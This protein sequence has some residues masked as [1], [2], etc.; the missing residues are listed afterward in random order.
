MN[1]SKKSQERSGQIMGAHT[2]VLGN[3]SGGKGKGVRTAKISFDG[4][5]M[6]VQI[7]GFE[8]VRRAET[9]MVHRKTESA[10]V[11]E[12]AIMLPTIT[13][14]VMTTAVYQPR[15]QM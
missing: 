2:P 10:A 4:S 1:V 5:S 7:V 6:N 3:E 11:T 14:T 8:Y 12:N 13:T 9:V 15:F